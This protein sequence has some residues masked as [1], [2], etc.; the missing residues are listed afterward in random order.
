MSLGSL[1]VPI[2]VATCDLWHCKRC[3]LFVH[4]AF[5][6]VGLHLQPLQL[7]L[8]CYQR[9][10]ARAQRAVAV[11]GST[12]GLAARSFTCWGGAG[13]AFLA[14]TGSAKIK[15][16]ERDCAERG[17]SLQGD[18]YIRDAKNT[19]GHV[20]PCTYGAWHPSDKC[21]HGPLHTADRPETV[22]PLPGAHR[23]CAAVHCASV[24]PWTG[25]LC[26]WEVM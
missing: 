3:K 26:H 22:V 20:S 15:V 24:T 4:D 6:V 7:Y 12:R 14:V 5:V 16:Y 25:K 18:M 2:C 21:V 8:S 9:L 17:E 13:D 11:H 10:H 19:K 23:P 1:H